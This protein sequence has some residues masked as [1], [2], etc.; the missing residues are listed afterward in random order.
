MLVFSVK[1]TDDMTVGCAVRING[2]WTKLRQ[3]GNEIVG[4][5]D[6]H[7]QRRSI[8]MDE[9]QGE[10]RTY[11]CANEDGEGMVIFGP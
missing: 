2:E 10:L 8:L 11:M 1:K 7:E 5:L 3:E 6:G 4:M 9:S